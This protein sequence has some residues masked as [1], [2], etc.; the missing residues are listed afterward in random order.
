MAAAVAG[1]QG[2]NGRGPQ[3]REPSRADRDLERL[4]LARHSR[5]RRRH[6]KRRG[7]LLFLALLIAA[8]IALTL[9]T[10]AF[11]GRQILLTTCSLSDLRPLA[12]GENS[13]LYTNNMRLLG[14]VPSATNRQPLPLAKISPW[15]PEATVAIEDARFW[16]Q[17]AL[18]YQG[19]ARAF[20]QD[21]SKGH[22]VQGGSTITQEL[23]RNLYIGNPQRTLSRKVKEACLAAKLFQ[24]HSRKQI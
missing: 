17:G 1:N 23:V 15:L 16:Q 2:R 22:I 8:A 24:R 13:F 18:D 5:L 12:L 4:F 7:I 21:I 20:Y 3:R 10:V 19:I 11:T 14:V 9:A 6:R